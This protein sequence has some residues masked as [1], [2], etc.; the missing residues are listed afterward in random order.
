MKTE[1]ANHLAEAL[2]GRPIIADW[3]VSNTLSPAIRIDITAPLPPEQLV[4]LAQLMAAAPHL[5]ELASAVAGLDD[6]S[7]GKADL[8]RIIARAKSAILRA[9]G[10]L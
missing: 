6:P 4:A 10:A 8:D 3:D 9:G 2:K 1:T 5:L 7:K